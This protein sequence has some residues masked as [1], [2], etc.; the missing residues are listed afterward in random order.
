MKTCGYHEFGCIFY[1]PTDQ[2][3]LLHQETCGY[4]R[5][6][7]R[8]EELQ[9]QLALRDEEITRLNS[10]LAEKDDSKA[11]LPKLNE[12]IDS[13]SRGLEKLDEDSSRFIEDAKTSLQKTKTSVVTNSMRVLDS[14]KEAVESARHEFAAKIEELESAAKYKLRSFT[15]PRALTHTTSTYSTSP[16]YTPPTPT[17]LAPTTPTYAILTNPFVSEISI[18]PEPINEIQPPQPPQPLPEPSAA[19]PNTTTICHNDVTESSDDS[20]DDD[21]FSASSTAPEVSAVTDSTDGLS[22]DSFVNIRN[23]SENVA[24][25]SHDEVAVSGDVTTANPDSEP[26]QPS[27]EEDE[28]MTSLIEASKKEYLREEAL[29]MAEEESIRQAMLLS[30]ME[31]DNKSRE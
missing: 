19:E 18:I 4:G 25:V 9:Q 12:I 21:V 10:V 3:L 16:L 20:D 2:E 17:D 27:E 11:N 14:I 30:M 22:M 1:A 29:R 8:L 24:G 5:L 28:E 7:H 31:M 15:T 6:I 26:A 13:V 23:S